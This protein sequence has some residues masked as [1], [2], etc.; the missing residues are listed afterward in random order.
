VA[1]MRKAACLLAGTALLLTG[2]GAL[3]GTNSLTGSTDD[4]RVNIT[5]GVA[6]SQSSTAIIVGAKHG[7]FR[8]NGIDL[9]LAPAATGAGAITQVI[10]GQQQV[11]LGGISPVI[12]AAASHIPVEIVSGAVADK[13]SAA[14]TQYQ[15]MV[16]GNSPIKSFRDLKGKTVAVNSLKCCWEFW[17]KEA[18][19]KDGGAPGSVRLVQLPFPDQVTAL[20]Q[21]KVDA[22]STAQPYATSLRQ[23]G[24]RDIGDSPSVAFGDPDADNTVFFMSRSFVKNNPGIVERWRRAV[25]QSSD[26]ANAHPKETRA[27]IVKQTSADPRLVASAPLPRYTADLSRKVVEKEASFTVKYGVVDSAPKYSTFVAP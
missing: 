25:K 10:N 27:A 1:L 9:K 19:E 21:G 5:A 18:V 11:A 26:Y 7:F 12:T 22:I 16:A 2:C 8:Q 4:G 6:A 15:T 3:S 13:P 14:G 17:I 20:K 24:F 23:Q